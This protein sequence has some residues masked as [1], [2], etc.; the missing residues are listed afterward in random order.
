MRLLLLTADPEPDAVLPALALLDHLVQHTSPE[1]TALLETEPH[2]LT[3]VDARA[4]PLRAA[5]LCRLLHDLQ[6]GRPVVAVV[7]DRDLDAVTREWGVADMVLTAAGPAEVDA[8][9][10]LAGHRR[11][12]IAASTDLV[13]GN[14]VI[15]EQAHT[16]RVHDKTI[17]LTFLEFTLLAHLA[18]HGGRAFSRLELVSQVWGPDFEG[19]CRTVDVHVRRLRAKLGAPCSGLIS[20]VRNVGYKLNPPDGPAAKPSVSKPMASD[21]ARA[22]GLGVLA[23]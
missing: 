4:I 5:T 10:R 3:L 13:L 22:P 21:Q 11:G 6:T 23:R 7:T 15:D 12:M 17:D 20:T 1:V 8:R 9:L 19:S 2:D 16:V 14:L 18:R